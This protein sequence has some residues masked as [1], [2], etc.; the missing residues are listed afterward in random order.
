MNI[1]SRITH[2]NVRTNALI[3]LIIAAL[4]ILISRNY[5]LL[6]HTLAE[7]ISVVIAAAL[8]ILVWNTRNFF[9]NQYLIVIGIAYFFIAILD[10]V[11][12]LTFEGMS[13]FPDPNPDLS[14]Q[15]WIAARYVQA[16]TLLI[17]PLYFHRKIELRVIVL[18]YTFATM[19]ILATI[20]VWPIFP[21]SFIEGSGLTPFKIIS[22]YL[23]GLIMVGAILFLYK[24][25]SKLKPDIYLLIVLSILFTIASELTFTSYIRLFDFSVVVGHLLKIAAFFLLYHAIVVTGFSRP[26]ELLFRNLK[27][28]ENALQAAHDELEVKVEQ[29]TLELKRSNRTLN[30]LSRANQSMLH[31]SE[32]YA[33]LNEICRLIIEDSNYNL[34]WVDY[35]DAE[36]SNLILTAG[37]AGFDPD[38]FS[39]LE[40]TRSDGKRTL[41]PSSAVVRSRGA[42]VIRERLLQDP[43][44]LS[45]RHLLEEHN[46]QAMIGLPLKANS[47][48]IG[49]L[50]VCSTEEAPFDMGEIGLLTEMAGDLAFGITALRIRK[51]HELTVNNLGQQIERLNSLRQ[52]DKAISSSMDPLL[53]LEVLLD[54]VTT[55]LKVDAAN[56]LTFDNN[57]R[58]LSF[59]V[60]R[61]FRTT[62][63]QHTRLP[64]GEG[65]AGRAAVERDI[66]HIP[67]LSAMP[68]G[69]DR[70]ETFEQEGFV[71]YHAVPLY[72][73]GAL[74]GVLE[75]F[76]RTR[77]SP[78]REWVEYLEVLA[79][80]AAIA[81]NNSMLFDAMHRSNVEMLQAYDSTLEGWVS[82]LDLRDKETE[83]HT[84]RVTDMT[85]QLAIELGIPNSELE[86]IR[87]G[88]L[89]HDIGKM[90]VPDNILLKPGELDEDEWAVMR[91]HPK[92]ASRLLTKINYLRPAVDIPYYHHEK[93]DGTGYPKGLKGDNIPLGARIFAVVDV[94]DALSS[95]RPYRKAWPKEKVIRYL[96]DESGTHFD[97][98]VVEAFYKLLVRLDLIGDEA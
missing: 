40:F 51:E 50:C 30:A 71:S 1:L 80:Q 59:A 86:Q 98:A 33:L 2:R 89:L 72:A 22:E 88:A 32:E 46:I 52:I 3:G 68:E 63:L 78:A 85:V 29:R 91:E 53:A 15:S 39:S 57:A 27:E 75:V 14:I 69:L 66:L 16:I 90:A 56:V 74:N 61:G 28:S 38:V 58:V 79:A 96:K 73:K 45:R 42:P 7:L 24:H 60:G 84:R 31:I 5:Y 48:L 54:Q 35:I 76:H 67:D 18:A 70:S 4:L 20:F 49:V 93:W 19:I 11:H 25:R 8:F 13:V 21:K 82:A 47:T 26:V 81:I 95:D 10:V 65:Y 6:F 62:A 36:L 34:A 12:L 92:H 64:L 44:F 87:R 17:A 41:G 55:Q 94:W 83:G 37:M 9:E 97:P 77:V 23:I 43:T